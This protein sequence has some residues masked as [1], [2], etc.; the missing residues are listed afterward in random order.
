MTSNLSFKSNVYPLIEDCVHIR[1]E[2]E[3]SRYTVELK[4][5]DIEEIGDI[6]EIEE[7][8]DIRPYRDFNFVT[9]VFS[10]KKLKEINALNALSFLPEPQA[11]CLEKSVGDNM[12]KFTFETEKSASN[13]NS[14]CFHSIFKMGPDDKKEFVRCED[15]GISPKNSRRKNKNTAKGFPVLLKTDELFESDFSLCTFSDIFNYFGD[16][17]DHSRNDENFDIYRSIILQRGECEKQKNNF[18]KSQRRALNESQS[19]QNHM[20][21][22]AY[23]VALDYKG[24]GNAATFDCNT[25]TAG[26]SSCAPLDNAP[27]VYF[28][29][30]IIELPS[31]YRNSMLEFMKHDHSN[32]M[33]EFRKNDHS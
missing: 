28:K 12:L 24:G 4:I 14:A 30:P 8:G 16:D 2:K 29:E 6:K 11:W 23:R 18:S 21:R 5:G 19:L 17:S 13:K 26:F 20:L 25:N 27:S 33:L 3:K 1:W 32:S 15:L 10:E 7:I 22:Y 31:S 9:R